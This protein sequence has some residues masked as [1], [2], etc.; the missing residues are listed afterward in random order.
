MVLS[1][2]DAE[3]DQL[4]RQLA[5]LTGQSITETVK[6]ALRERLQHEQRRRG[7]RL[8]RAKISRIVADIAT[9]PVV[10][11]RPPDELVGYDEFGLPTQ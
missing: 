8:D 7:K 2:K 3:T 9:L 5:R 4:A 10:D 11:N 1:I 6:A